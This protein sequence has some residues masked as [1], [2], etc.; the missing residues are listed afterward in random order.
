MDLFKY[1]VNEWYRNRINLSKI[2]YCQIHVTKRC[3]NNCIHC[4][5]KE[6]KECDIDISISE[7]NRLIDVIKKQALSLGLSAR[8]DF[9]GGDPLLYPY[10]GEAIKHC[11]DLGI[12][13]GFKCNPETL[14]NPSDF[15]INSLLRSSGVSLSLDG[16]N[17]THDYFRR[18]GSFDCTINAIKIIKELGIHLRL[19]TTVSRYNISDLIPLLDFLIKE[20]IVVDDYT[21]ARYWSMENPNDIISSCDL[22]TIFCEMTQYMRNLFSLPSFY[23][24]TP[25]NRVVPQIMFGFKEH[26]W[27]PFLVQEGLIDF[28]I[29]EKVSHANNCINCTATKHFY[30]I[31]PDL[32]VYKCRKLPETKITMSE[33][34]LLSACNYSKGTELECKKCKFYNGCG[35]CSAITKCFTGKIFESEPFCP[36]KTY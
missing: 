10:L 16:L 19:N 20:R 18:E 30:I 17:K 33:F 29:Q 34:G 26:Q 3:Q 11:D 1:Y 32:S 22:K 31:D 15:I 35:G 25:D 6:L 12:Q 8:I 5:F 4:Y 13:Y 23:F 9:T 27:Y 7:L 28:D 14:L 24:R 21:W 2:F 36:Y